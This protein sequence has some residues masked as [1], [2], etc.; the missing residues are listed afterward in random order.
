M[1]YPN[2]E[3]NTY[4]YNGGDQAG[5]YGNSV[6]MSYCK[7]TGFDSTTAMQLDNGWTVTGR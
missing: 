1:K 4:N 2:A 3:W 6:S 5:T 7:L